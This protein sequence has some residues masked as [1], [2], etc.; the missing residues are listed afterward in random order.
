MTQTSNLPK[1]CSFLLNEVGSEEILTPEGFSQDQLL[2][3]ESAEKFMQVEVFPHIE[4]T[5]KGDHELMKQLLLKA[6]EQGLLMIDIPEIY[7]GLGV[8]KTTSML[9]T[10]KLSIY[11]S[12]ATSYGAHVG[13]GTLPLVFF[14]NNEQKERYL[15]KLATGELLAAYALTEPGSGSDALAAKTKAV[16][17]DDGEHYVI[18]GTKM[19]ITN[20]GF[21]DLF[22]VFC[23]IDGDKFTAFLV[24]A[25][26]EG[27]SL[28][29]EEKKMGLKGS[30]TRLLILENVKV[31]KENLLGE[32][33]KGHK[34]AFNIL[35]IGRF[36]LG[37]GVLGGSKRLVGI[38]AKYANE[39]VA[40][41]QP[42]SSFGA[43]QEK[44]GEMVARLYALESSCYRVAGYMDQVLDAIEPDDEAYIAKTMKAIEEFAVEDSIMK[45]FGSETGVF[46]ADEAVQIHG[47]MG[48]SAEYEV[49]RS[50]RDMRINTIFEGTNEINRMLIPGTILKLTMKGQLNLFEVIQQVE[51]TLA[52][53]TKAQPPAQDD[54]TLAF[55]KFLVQQ[56]KHL[57]VYAANQAIQKHMADLRNQQEILIALAD[58]II[59]VYA[60]DSTLSRT[61]QLVRDQGYEAT[62]NQRAATRLFI[63][64]RYNATRMGAEQLLSNIASGDR[65]T[66][67]LD[68]IEKLSVSPRVNTIKLKRKLAQL[69]IDRERYPF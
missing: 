44:L 4:A 51:A 1:G 63:A 7:G 30:S 68:A 42:I 19:W 22:T 65:L 37:V 27:V 17:T 23:Q 54:E 48:Y 24:E 60:M 33:G 34:I 13:I 49:E 40:F 10:E 11:G 26:R 58:L 67:H 8:D 39:R 50:Y 61:L 12:F 31:P 47:G 59:D 28:G 64:Q 52:E 18:T 14:G 2:F 45:I 25:D 15:P 55:D 9:V 46:V 38:A 41:G 69:A 56:A 29:A 6:G 16:L 36:K 20:A 43:I 21:A 32:I 5:E 35:N 62:D 3:A 66:P 57:A 53:P